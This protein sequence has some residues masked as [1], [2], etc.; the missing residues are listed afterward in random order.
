M[1]RERGPRTRIK[2]P[3]TLTVEATSVATVGARESFAPRHAACDAIRTSVAGKDSARI[4]TYATAEAQSCRVAS[5]AAA[6]PPVRATV[7]ATADG[8]AKRPTAGPMPSASSRATTQPMANDAVTATVVARLAACRSPP[9]TAVETAFVVP[10]LMNTI[11]PVIASQMA[12]AG[13]IAASCTA[14]T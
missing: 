7:L 3:T 14:E 4:L 13:P 2:S 12:H 9:P 5:T 11:S 8:S 6:S 1:P 10:T